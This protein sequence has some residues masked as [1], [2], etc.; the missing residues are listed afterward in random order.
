[1]STEE[2]TELRDLVAQTLE[3]NGVLNKI[4]AELRANVFLALEEQDA[5]KKKTLS[6]KALKSYL[7]TSEGHLV[8]SVVREFLEFFNLDF[9]LAVL[10]PESNVSK[11]SP[12]ENLINEFNMQTVDPKA[13]LLAELLKKKQPEMK[14]A[15]PP[16]SP[17]HSKIPQR[18]NDKK[19]VSFDS[20]E[21]KVTTQ[22]Q[23]PVFDNEDDDLFKELG[24]S[25]ISFKDKENEPPSKPKPSWLSGGD[26][27]NTDSPK[28]KPATS[29]ATSLGSLKDA[30]P[31]AGMGGGKK[32]AF[33]SEPA[34]DVLSPEWDELINIDKKINDLGFEI[35][36]EEN[37][38]SHKNSHSTE[39]NSR[40]LSMKSS[41]KITGT[42]TVSTGEKKT[43]A[44]DAYNYEDDF[45]SS[46]KSDLSIT[47]EIE[48]NLS[49]GS[50]GNSKH[51]D[52]VTSDH[53][54]SQLSDTGMDYG[55]DA[56]FY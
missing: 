37:S 11:P 22:A 54:V 17:R 14:M 47:E 36:V 53:T 42:A 41:G 2:D 55:E 32:T 46:G 30:P 35:P 5:L 16:A 15:S 50:F 10:D 24:V 25:P 27:P 4:R 23:S 29:K 45:N 56:E 31:L 33:T 1:M 13:P 3:T 40:S 49:I 34:I 9:T 44:K 26:S 52:A 12:R 20:K 43:S 7:E 48:E 51:D 19:P 21:K 39:S 28:S 6:N 38:L 8:F 18:L